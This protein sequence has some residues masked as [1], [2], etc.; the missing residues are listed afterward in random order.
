MKENRGA[1]LRAEVRSLAVHLRGI[2]CLPEHVEQ[3]FVTHLRGI[4]RDLYHFRVA[5]FIGAHV[6]VG[7]ILRM[8]AAVAY[9]GIN[10]SRNALERRLHTPEAAGAKCRNLA[11]GSSPRFKTLFA[12]NVELL[13]A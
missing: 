12:S 11:H 3:F 5:G 1:V 9:G 8:P 13:D 6:L 7:R 4:K 10:H 2:V